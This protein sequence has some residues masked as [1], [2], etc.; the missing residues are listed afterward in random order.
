MSIS[1]IEFLNLAKN[2][3]AA[4]KAESQFRCVANRAY[5]GAYH[6][7]LNIHK[8]LPSAGQLP[9]Q[10]L[11]VH[12]TLIYQLTHPSFSKVDNEGLYLLSQSVGYILKGLKK[13]RCHADYTI[14]EHFNIELA[15][16]AIKQS[17]SIFAK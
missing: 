12:E 10:S 14:E 8:S 7:S 1:D 4:A 6:R 15:Q 5:Y 11:G 3:L 16:N 9:A 13:I 2:D 17:E